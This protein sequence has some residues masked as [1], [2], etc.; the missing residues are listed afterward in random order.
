MPKKSDRYYL[1]TKNG[2]DYL[3]FPAPVAVAPSLQHR[4]KLPPVM[5]E[6]ASQD[7]P[8]CIDLRRLR[9]KNARYFNLTT[10]LNIWTKE[11]IANITGKAPKRQSG[12][13]NGNKI[14]K[15]VYGRV[16]CQP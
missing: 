12:K 7:D 8:Y 4:Y 6:D 15:D 5:F 9:G 13:W 2:V 10:G 3:C 11:G 1:E 14:F 16:P